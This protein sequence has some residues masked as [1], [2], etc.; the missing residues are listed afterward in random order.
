[1]SPRRALAGSDPL[2][3]LHEDGRKLGARNRH[4]LAELYQ[5]VKCAGGGKWVPR[6]LIQHPSPTIAVGRCR[7]CGRWVRVGKSGR[8]RTHYQPPESSTPLGRRW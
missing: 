6:G 2:A 5:P 4:A 7:D 3:D 8:L 1:M